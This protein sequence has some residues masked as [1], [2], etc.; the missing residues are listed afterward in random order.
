MQLMTK[1]SIYLLAFLVGAAASPQAQAPQSGAS[2]AGGDPLAAHKGL[3]SRYCVTCHNDKLQTAGF[4]LEHADLKAPTDAAPVWEKV[5][6]KLRT[7][8][9]PPQ[10]APRPEVAAASGL[11]AYLENELDR[12]AAANPN[13]G[14][15]AMHRLNRTE[16]AHAVRDMLAVEIDAAELLPADDVSYGF[17]N[18]AEVLSI[19]PVLTEK[20]IAAAEKISRAAV[21]DHNVKAATAEYSLPE[22]VMQDGRMSEDLPFGSRGGMAVRH[23]FPADGEYSVHVR[24]QRNS[25]NYIRGI[26]EPHQLDI[27]LDGKRVKLLTIGG[28]NHG[29]SGPLYSFVNKDYKGDEAQEKYEFDADL[30]LEAPLH[31]AAGPH[32]V[33]VAFLD[34]TV[35]PETIL[36]PERQLFVDKG[37]YKGGLPMI[38]AVGIHGP[39]DAKGLGNTP[40]RSRV[41]T[42]RPAAASEEQN[43]A[44]TI[45]TRLARLAYR[46]P[47]SADDVDPLMALF[48]SVR[49]TGDFESAIEMALRGLLVSTEFLFRMEADPANAAP[50]TT[51]RISDIELASRLSFFLW[52]SIPDEPL[53]AAAEKGLLSKPEE[54]EKQVRRM[55]ADKR[56]ESLADNFAG[57]WL[58]LRNIEHV[59]PDERQF[60]SF[61]DGLR[62][63]FLEETREFI[64]SIAREDRSVLDLLNAD[65]TYLNERL[66]DYYG[67]PGV[68]GNHFRR[69]QMPDE[70]RRGLLGQASI[71]T[72]TSYA[73]RTSPTLRG[74][75]VLENILG[76]PPPPPP[77][78]VP[79]L[80]EEA[81]RGPV[82]TMRQRLE[83]HRAN[84]TCASCHARMD[85]IG[86]ALDNFDGTGSWRLKEGGERGTPIDPAGVLP[87]GTKFSGPADLRRIL[88]GR[89]SQVAQTVT[90]KLLIYALGRG[91]EYYDEPAVRKIL[92]EA[93]GKDYRWSSLILGI[94]NST[95]FQMRRTKDL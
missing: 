50:G 71:L 70:N 81:G 11:A 39:L 34:E 65:Y 68:Y 72:V 23:N 49:K 1:Q 76:T 62:A 87:D 90:E 64:A 59:K 48:S 83:Q 14:R 12:A 46:R 58:F 89:R 30:K 20:Y 25:D 92:R 84:P 45:L 15:K 85:P 18:I 31:A 47:V 66:A 82:L 4:S 63:A 67:I 80:K 17:D 35:E 42:C 29:L 52:S 8:A 54:L 3:L 33:Q 74:K 26:T 79:S 22:E 40:S 28:E 37:D 53:L 94:V 60:P 55:L 69:V 5:I 77:P 75:W 13:P 95:P 88:A 38:A 57:Q 16:Y 9:M 2:D 36:M 32:L 21:G 27:R 56:A 73:N 41:F 78:D 10:G 43:C 93:E 44:T 51:H 7:G 86:L 6:R 91:I 61:D 24:L 19:S